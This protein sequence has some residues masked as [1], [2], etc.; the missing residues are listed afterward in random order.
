MN[1]FFALKGSKRFYFYLVNGFVFILASQSIV[2]L[3]NIIS[4][5]HGQTPTEQ[6]GSDFPCDIVLR[7][8][9]FDALYHEVKVFLR[10]RQTSPFQKQ[11][12]PVMSHN[13]LFLLPALH[14]LVLNGY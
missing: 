6:V 5:L 7:T 8:G 10:N 1:I 11:N 2:V 9:R 4:L 14:R 13:I 3:D 12:T